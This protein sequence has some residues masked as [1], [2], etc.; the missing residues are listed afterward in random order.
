MIS[1]TSVAYFALG[2]GGTVL[3]SDHDSDHGSAPV[4]GHGRA[5]AT[6]EFDSELLKDAK[7]R[8]LELG[9]YRIR[10]YYPVESQKS[11]VRF[12][13]HAAVASERLAE[14]ERMVENRRHKLRDEVITATRMTP[15]ALFDEPGLT[16]FRRRILVRLRRMLPELPID[17][18]FV[19][20]FQLTVKSL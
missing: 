13:L 16:S 20:D 17:E 1:L 5:T 11:T 15:L 4:D 14:A 6:V 9:E 18:V 10:A 3:A 8:G 7:I 12:V 2:V 19:S